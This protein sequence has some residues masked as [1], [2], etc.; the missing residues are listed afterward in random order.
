MANPGY[1]KRAVP[2]QLPPTADAF[3]H[4]PVREASIAALID[5]LVDGAVISGKALAAAHPLYGQAA[6]LTALNALSRAGHLRRVRERLD[7]VDGSCRWVTRTYF[8]RT[9]H[10]DAWWEAFCADGVAPVD[11]SPADPP[12]PADRP[13]APSQPP[14]TVAYD[15]LA[16]ISR[17]EPRLTLSAADCSKLAPLA[18]EW[19]ARDPSRERFN[20]ALCAGLPTQVHHPAGFLATRLRDKLPPEAPPEPA[21]R[22]ILE[23]TECRTPGRP[24]ALPGG[25]CAGCREEPVP[26]A[27]ASRPDITAHVDNLRRIIHNVGRHP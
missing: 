25:L 5:M 13:P 6:C 22:V 11:R 12:P 4:L 20:E 16:E 24:E 7:G 3:A 19:L 27:P 23:C 14:R 9:P 21:P 26:E 2:E 10:D 1:G 8:S 15:A 18:A 17:F